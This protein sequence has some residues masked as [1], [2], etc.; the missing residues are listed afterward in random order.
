M[1]YNLLMSRYNVDLVGETDQALTRLA[2]STSSKA[3]AIRKAI[4]VAAWVDEVQRSGK[5]LLVEDSKG[6]LREVH[7]A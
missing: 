1:M 5:K 2:E 4:S 7:W 6:N 3:E